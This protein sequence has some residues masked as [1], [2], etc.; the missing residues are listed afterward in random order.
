MLV[1]LVDYCVGLSL[2]LLMLPALFLSSNDLLDL[3][4]IP[5]TSVSS[6][7]STLPRGATCG[8]VLYVTHGL[9][10]VAGLNPIRTRS[11]S[12]LLVESCSP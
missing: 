3:L 7:D 9:I 5:S 2:S 8:L 10:D 11:P 6:I 1:L 4:F 12:L